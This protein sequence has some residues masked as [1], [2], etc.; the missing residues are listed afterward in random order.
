MLE[1]KQPCWSRS[2]TWLL[3][4]LVE[5]LRILCKLHLAIP[6]KTTQKHTE[7]F[8]GFLPH[9]P[10][11][12]SCGA[13]LD[14]QGRFGQAH[15]HLFRKFTWKFRGRN[16]T[17]TAKQT[18]PSFRC[19]S[20]KRYLK[21]K[22]KL[23]SKK[24]WIS[25]VVFL[26]FV[27]GGCF[28]NNLGRKECATKKSLRFNYC[29]PYH[30]WDWYISLYIYHKNQQNSCRYSYYIH[31][32]YWYMSLSCST[33]HQLCFPPWSPFVEY[34]PFDWPKSLKCSS[35][36]TQVHRLVPLATLKITKGVDISSRE[37]DNYGNKLMYW[38]ETKIQEKQNNI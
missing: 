28:V 26:S 12:A 17:K 15:L 38:S 25:V 3:K 5:F 29:T 36:W 34:H 2:S 6:G 30:P 14:L 24:L 19:V 8:P 9:Q 16:A 7:I 23:M 18:V 32:W 33:H 31:E 1:K 37:V 22:Y 13:I 35:R 21:N 27:S 4:I 20:Q 10:R 11:C